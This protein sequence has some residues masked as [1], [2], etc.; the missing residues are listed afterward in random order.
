MSKTIKYSV[1]LEGV[2]TEKEI[3]FIRDELRKKLKDKAINGSSLEIVSFKEICRELEKD[4]R[5]KSPEYLKVVVAFKKD[6]IENKKMD[7]VEELVKAVEDA[8]VEVTTGKII[9]TKD[10]SAD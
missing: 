5:E 1:E 2:S 10:T 9:G 7:V 3:P 6:S 4:K 8:I